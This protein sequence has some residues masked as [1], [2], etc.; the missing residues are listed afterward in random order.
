MNTFYF[1]ILLTCII[2]V[3]DYTGDLEPTFNA[4]EQKLGFYTPPDTTEIE[5]EPPFYRSPFESDS[6][7]FEN[8][9]TNINKENKI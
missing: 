9:N 3:L 7:N 6:L 1:H 8:N 5:T 2:L 4:F